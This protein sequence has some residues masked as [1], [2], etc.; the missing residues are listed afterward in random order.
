MVPSDCLKIFFYLGIFK[1]EGRHAE[2]G[3]A[4]SRLLPTMCQNG[5][6][7]PTGI[8]AILGKALTVDECV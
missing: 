7:L 8:E 6:Q 5:V 4:L 3:D 1:R 2:Q